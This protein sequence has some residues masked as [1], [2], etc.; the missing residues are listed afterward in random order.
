MAYLT[1]KVIVY[2]SVSLED[3][4]LRQNLTHAQRALDIELLRLKNTV[5]DYAIW[6][7]TYNFVRDNN[8]EYVE[9]NFSPST[10]E[11]NRLNLVLILDD[12]NRVVFEQGYD[13][14]HEQET[15]VS[16]QFVHQLIN[17]E[18]VARADQLEPRGGLLQTPLG[19]MFLAISPILNS[20]MEGP[21]R[22]TM[23][24]GR[25]LN[26]QIVSSLQAE[27]GLLL[28]FTE[29]DITVLNHEVGE[30][31]G[32]H[33]AVSDQTTKAIDENTLVGYQV[34]KD[35]SEQPILLMKVEQDRAI[36]QHSKRT[37]FLILL[38]IISQAVAFGVVILFNLERLVLLPLGGMNYA[39]AAIGAQNDLSRRLPVLGKYEIA[40]LTN[41]INRMLG[42]LEVS[43][44]ELLES[45]QRY[46]FLSYHDALTGLKNRTFFEQLIEDIHKDYSSYLPLSIL[47][48]DVDGLK[49]INDTLGHQEGDNLLKEASR[50]LAAVTTADKVIARIGGDEFCLILPRTDYQQAMSHKN[51]IIELLN[52]YNDSEPFFPLSISVGV[53]TTT[54]GDISVYELFQQADDSMYNYKLSQSDSPK[55]KIIDL[56]QAALSERDFIA[57]GHVQRL[58]IM[59]ERMVDRLQLSDE[60]RRNLILL[61]KVH[62]LGKVGIPDEILFKSE[63]LTKEEYGKM[64][65]HSRIGYNI[66]S[67]SKEL[68]HIANLI[69]NQQ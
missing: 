66:A 41:T 60:H 1:W 46:K 4:Y 15:A 31:T 55:S 24:M 10:F 59:A 56:L 28:S 45:E 42:A 25:Y 57:Q 49:F 47:N 38:L 37:T 13:Y 43:Q 39:L 58:V 36:Y 40:D 53:A 61:A 12:Q 9:S 18:L 64:Q 17:R 27:V 63:K 16:K 22:G 8:K 3:Q 44:K 26:E 29:Y 14:L 2:R 33:A 67:R 54:T 5:T 20:D 65:E 30:I 21:S 35:L 69:A 68:S 23:V 51:K 7:Y 11:T 19:Y 34:V 32:S 6:D 50:I 62:D 52:S 48:A